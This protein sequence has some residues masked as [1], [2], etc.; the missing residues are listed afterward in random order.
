MA[1][2]GLFARFLRLLG[3]RRALAA[4]ALLAALLTL[5]T[6]RIG[7]Y[8]DDFAQLSIIERTH[9]AVRQ[10][11]L[12]DLYRFAPEDRAAFA[13]LVEHGPLPWFTDPRLKIHFFR[14]LASAFR[15]AEHALF[16]RWAPGHHLGSV[17]LYAALVF[18]AG[19]LYRAMLSVRGGGPAA[20]TATLAALCF[21]VA[22]PHGQPVYWVAG[23][24]L[25]VALLPAV[26][27]LAAHVRHVREGWRPGA[28]LAP[29]ALVISLLASEAALGGVLYW[30]AFDAL[31]PA[32]APASSPRARLRASL[33]ALAIAAA[34]AIAY[35]ALGYGAAHSG[36]YLD[37]AGDPVSFARALP[38]RIPALLAEAFTGFPSD[39]SAV[40]SA[41]PFV[42]A[43]IV[44]TLA[45]IAI[46]RLVWPAVPAEERAALRWMLPGAFA[47]LV[48][49]AGGFP[50]GR[51]LSFPSLG[52]AFFIAVLLRRSLDVAS[53]VALAAGRG[54]LI[55]VHL[56]LAPIALVS[57]AFTTAG[58]AE[59]G[60]HAY[61]DAEIRGPSPFRVVVLAA[62]DPL[63]AFYPGLAGVLYRPA[64][65]GSWQV[66]ST[67]KHEHRLTRTAPDR[68]RLD[69]IG[70]RMLES[71]FDENFRARRVPFAV[72]DRF[73]LGGV[74]VTVVAAEGGFPTAIEAAFDV[75][76]DDPSLILLTWREGR[77]R[78]F[79]PP[80]VGSSVVL[81]WEPGPFL[82]F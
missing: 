3:H 71:A 23:C 26:L 25:L 77:L 17:L 66:L 4:I 58:I 78:R 12:L 34:Y 39:L 8:A 28:Y 29:L 7:F 11:P 43:G 68:I 14:P 13:Q 56:V 50:G 51:L 80:P 76:A 37:P 16:G 1:T 55:V 54:F 45:M 73:P 27:A 44:A 82:F 63:V 53:G 40:F 32:P 60:F 79:S 38:T 15:L 35:K 30:L 70:G 72:G 18:A 5:P 46:A 10:I 69:V 67:A 52:V 41:V 19:L 57:G 31:G 9:P 64:D 21:A 24:H 74:T 42:V 33:P 20:V 22:E 61:S 49:A 81:P 48:L 36:A 62:S 75:P 47:S 6:L 2:A 59:R 65:A